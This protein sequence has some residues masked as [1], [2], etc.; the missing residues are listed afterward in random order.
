METET[1]NT[2]VPGTYWILPKGQQTPVGQP[3]KRLFVHVFPQ[4]I[5]YQLLLDTDVPLINMYNAIAGIMTNDQDPQPKYRLYFKRTLVKH[6]DDSTNTFTSGATFL[7]VADQHTLLPKNHSG[8]LWQCETCVESFH[9]FEKL[10]HHLMTMKK[11]KMLNFGVQTSWGITIAPQFIDT[12]SPSNQRRKKM[13]DALKEPEMEMDTFILDAEDLVWEAAV[14][15]KYTAK[16]SKKWKANQE[17]M[18][19]EFL[20]SINIGEELPEKYRR[21]LTTTWD[22]YKPYF[23]KIVEFYQGVRGEKLHYRN[24]FA[25]GTPASL[26]ELANPEEFIQKCT[27]ASPEMKKK[28]LAT[29]NLLMTIVENAAMSATGKHAF[30]KRYDD[31][32]DNRGGHDLDLFLKNIDRIRKMIKNNQLWSNYAI[33]A[34]GKRKHQEELEEKLLEASENQKK[35]K[36]K[37]AVQKF[38]ASKFAIEA[39]AD[40]IK[41]ATTKIEAEA[42]L[43]KIKLEPSKWLNGTEFVVT[44]LQILSGGRREASDITVG[45]WNERLE[46]EDGTAIV[47]RHFTK[48]EGT[49]ETF[50]HLDGVEVYLMTAYESAKNNQF[51]EKEFSE[52]TAFFVNSAGT[53]YISKGGNPTHLSAWREITGRTEDKPSTFR[54]TMATWSLTTD[55]V[56]R[57]NSA[58]VCAHSLE[59]MTKV[60]AN[61]QKKREE[62]VNVLKRYRDEEL[63]LGMALGTSKGRTDFFQQQL[64]EELEEKQRKLRLE[65]YDNTLAKVI[66]L[67]RERNAEEHES[68][69]DKPASDESR[70]SLIELIAEERQSGVPVTQDVGFLADMLLT[71]E[72]GKKR[73]YVSQ[74]T[75]IE[76]ILSV[77]DSP[78]FA[79][80]HAAISLTKVLIMAASAMLGPDVETI[81]NIVVDKWVQQIEYWSRKG[82]RLQNFRTRSALLI[83]AN[84]AG[85]VDQYSV[86]NPIIA[87]Q[88]KI[89][90][91]ARRKHSQDDQTN[92]DEEEK[93][94]GKI[95]KSPRTSKRKPEYKD[96]T[97]QTNARKKLKYT[98]EKG[99]KGTENE[100]IMEQEEKENIIEQEKSDDN[101]EKVSKPAK[102]RTSPSPV[103]INW[104]PNAKRKP[105]WTHDDKVKL[106]DHILKYAKDPT[107]GRTSRGINDLELNVLPKISPDLIT[108]P[109]QSRDLDSITAQFYRYVP[110]IDYVSL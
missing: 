27:G 16:R 87:E 103:K 84:I 75:S 2:T 109:E 54:K 65:S 25:F 98:P 88:I 104:K 66:Q 58:F 33:R 46:Q 57:A 56:T 12:D 81:E 94:N 100:D 80:H 97:Q 108:N 83:L 72:K 24:F 61:K 6:E 96:S 39:E 93:E 64:P 101:V 5:A 36:M 68:N 11:H 23:R 40:L 105:N 21:Q 69:P 31:P 92:K 1:T 45:E 90:Q 60:Y 37:E 63:G 76:A 110:L 70:A 32:Q 48:L 43:I 107:L 52:N 79:D 34:E 55:L 47:E 42:D 82:P 51:P 19:P 8:C 7:L 17:K 49:L 74:E 106:L 38:L 85:N 41:I 86:G 89:M 53:D 15:R 29:H 9:K 13:D 91:N 73:Q 22:A 77:I 62:G 44:R 99:Q 50:L 3:N 28:S 10:I 95:R 4:K 26:V 20:N 71:R 35:S 18:S 30:Q 78:R 67:E 59:I 14:A 102:K